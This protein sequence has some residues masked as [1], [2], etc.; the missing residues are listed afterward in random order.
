MTKADQ[1]DPRTYAIIGAA[2][3]IHR[4]LGGGFLE[5]VYQEALDIEFQA[6]GITHCQ[7][8]QVPM[9][10]KGQR[11]AC[12]YRADFICFESV[13]VELKAVREL[14]GA[15]DAQVI[16][17]L[18]ATGFEVGLL[19]NF[20]AESLQYKRLILSRGNLRQSAKSAD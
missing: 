6:R 13:I 2:M 9:L 12:A 20:G 18:K 14:S 4:Q 19:V 8:A 11:L 15:H 1:R 17:Y 10:Y 3:K 7:E 5:A 16:N